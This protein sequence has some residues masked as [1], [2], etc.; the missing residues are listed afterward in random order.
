LCS[1][2]AW[3]STLP[4]LSLYPSDVSH[5]H[6]LLPPTLTPTRTPTST[7]RSDPPA[8]ACPPRLWHPQPRAERPHSATPSP[9]ST[10]P[11]VIP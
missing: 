6:A 9:S 3:I 5:T 10:P 4:C 1:P 7:P 8:H 2:A 11:T